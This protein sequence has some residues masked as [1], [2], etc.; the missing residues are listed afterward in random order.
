MVQVSI[1]T[2]EARGHAPWGVS[3]DAAVG[4]RCFGRSIVICLAS[5]TVF[6]GNCA[7]LDSTLA[8]ST[9]NAR[10]SAANERSI[11]PLAALEAGRCRIHIIIRETW[12]AMYTTGAISKRVS[13]RRTAGTLSCRIK[14]QV[15]SALGACPA[16]SGVATTE[17]SSSTLNA[18]RSWLQV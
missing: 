12:H 7:K 2:I 14:V 8:C 1:S 17:S 6:T 9:G 15:C 5:G 4:T 11:K 18:H 16:L 10:P 3:A 13:A